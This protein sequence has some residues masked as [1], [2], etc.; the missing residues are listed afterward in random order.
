MFVCLCIFTQ[1]GKSLLVNQVESCTEFAEAACDI[2]S[3][4]VDCAI[5]TLGLIPTAQP[6]VMDVSQVR[7]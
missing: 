7:A 1:N 3:Q 4:L 6:S 5:K 2:L